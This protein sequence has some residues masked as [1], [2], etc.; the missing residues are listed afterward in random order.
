MAGRGPARS[1][2]GSF[3][4]I[5]GRPLRKPLQVI[6]GCRAISLQDLDVSCETAPVTP[7][8]PAIVLWH[9]NATTRPPPYI[10]GDGDV[11]IAKWAETSQA[12]V[13][14]AGMQVRRFEVTK[15][16]VCRCLVAGIVR[17]RY[18]PM[19]EMKQF[20][21]ADVLDQMLVFVGALTERAVVI[22]ER[23]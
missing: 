21:P 8:T 10:A 11:S 22:S 1:W 16:K 7:L 2:S 17:Q 15:A 20:P 13:M 3:H 5:P 6:D 14:D 4:R 18:H 23:Y 9:G 19:N 12:A